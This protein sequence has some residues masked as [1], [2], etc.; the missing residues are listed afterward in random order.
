METNEKLIFEKSV[1]GR[2]GYSLPPLDVPET[3]LKTLFP[4]SGLREI[5]ADLPEVSESEMVR[6][7]VRLS[8]RNFCIDSGFYPLGSC[9]MKYNPK[10]NDE[11]SRFP[12][13]S[14]VHPLQPEGTVQGALEIIYSLEQSLKEILGMDRISFQ[15]VAGA[16]GEMVGLMMIRAALRARGENRK[17]ILIPDSAHGTNPASAGLAG[18]EVQ[19]IRS[20]KDGLIDLEDLKKHLDS[21]C[22]GLMLTNP[23]TLGLFEKEILKISRAVHEAGGLMY[24]DGANLNALLGV[25]RPGDM[26]FDVVHSN[27]HKTFSTPHGGGGPGAGAIGV[28]SH[29]AP[30]LPKPTVEKGES[31]YFF[32]EARPQ[33]IGKVSTFHGNFGNL[34]RAYAY[35]LTNGGEGLSEISR[36]AILNANYIRKKLESVFQVAQNRVC[37]HEVVFSAKKLKSREVHARDICKR[38][39]DYGFHPPTV[40]FPLIVEEA[41]MVEPTETESRETLDAFC[42]AMLAISK[43][44]ETSPELLL[45]APTTTPVG[46]LDETEAV[47]KLQVRW[48]RE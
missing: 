46:R 32:D 25:A 2:R 47:K 20:N 13:F 24:M 5:P 15:P 9:T 48:K 26:G 42:D 33:S 22:A 8:Q 28:K 11:V 3:D 27:L 40:Y 14:S 37:M 17:N 29:L 41:L 10:I 36:M 19:E 12:G 4:S 39:M 34:V 21:D 44:I 38:L 45:N 6:H 23:N 43:E 18:F 30:F 16:H 35:I 31:A 7:Y 1:R